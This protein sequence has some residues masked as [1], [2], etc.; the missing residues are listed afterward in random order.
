MSGVLYGI[1]AAMILAGAAMIG[2]G[3]PVNEFSF[4]NTLI[5]AGTTAVVGGLIVV[6]L[7]A[8]VGYLKRIAEIMALRAP[9]RAARPL[10]MFEAAAPRGAMPTRPPF[11]ARPKPGLREAP[12]PPVAPLP[13]LPEI[14]TPAQAEAIH[15]EPSFAPSLRNPETQAV[16]D[17]ASL[18]P[19]HSAMPPDEPEPP[20]DDRAAHAAAFDKPEPEP[21]LDDDWRLP[22]PE[23]ARPRGSESSYFDAM[24]PAEDKPARSWPGAEDRVEPEA[25]PEP[26]REQ[27]P[28]PESILEPPPPLEEAPHAYAE[29]EPA[30]EPMDEAS[31]ELEPRNVAIL[32]SG[33][34]DGMGYTLYVDGSIEAELPQGTLRFASINELRDHLERNT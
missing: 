3:I 33:V 15:D 26:P 16:A 14:S 4:G 32:K 5:M 17:E 21:P 1:G 31:P 27:E 8:A 12:V 29:A 9:L 2:F 22:P 19:L 18:S 34:V 6:A 20:A 30:P 10:D 7:A 13:P 28:A 25:Q 24:W 23:P 11:P